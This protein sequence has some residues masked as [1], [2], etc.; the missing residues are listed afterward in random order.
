MVASDRGDARTRVSPITYPSQPCISP[1]FNLKR[2][3]FLRIRKKG[4]LVG[5]E[6]FSPLMV[7]LDSSDHLLRVMTSANARYCDADGR[8]PTNEMSSGTSV[9]AIAWHRAGS[10]MQGLMNF[11]TFPSHDV[12]IVGKKVMHLPSWGFDSSSSL[13]PRP[14]LASC[15]LRPRY[16][17]QFKSDSGSPLL[18]RS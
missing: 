16:H 6:A 12:P 7:G 8:A 11:N 3:G 15:A 4:G 5:R 9:L 17:F 13:P 1:R 14:A 18:S 10:G 2:N